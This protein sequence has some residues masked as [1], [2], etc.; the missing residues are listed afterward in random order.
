[1]LAALQTTAHKEERFLYPVVVLLVLEAAPGLGALLRS[2]ATLRP[3]GRW[4]QLW[5]W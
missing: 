1:M 5:C 4:W 2:R 3:L